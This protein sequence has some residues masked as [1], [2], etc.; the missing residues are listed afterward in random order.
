VTSPGNTHVWLFLVRV[1]VEVMSPINGKFWS[2]SLHMVFVFCKSI[3]RGAQY[4]TLRKY[5]SHPSLVMYSL[6]TPP[7]KLKLWQQIGGGTANNK[8][9][10][11]TIMMGQ[12][13]TLSSS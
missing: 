2:L 10:G 5:F 8:P 1:V 4:V 9:P 7:I 12:S 6:A 13:E 11:P 3:S